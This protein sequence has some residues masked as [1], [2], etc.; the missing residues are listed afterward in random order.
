VLIS[1]WG[2]SPGELRRRPDSAPL[3][4]LGEQDADGLIDHV[5][6]DNVAAARDMTGHLLERGRGRIAAIGPQPHQINGTAQRRLEGY[7]Q[8][9][10]AAGKPAD[11][12]LEVPVRRLHRAEGADA[13]RRLLTVG[14]RPDALF[15]FSDQLALGAMHVAR[16][17]GIRVPDD[18]A[19]AGFDDVEDARYANPSL[20]TVAPDKVQIARAAMECVAHR[21]VERG[22][23]APAR[24]IIAGHHLEIRDSTGLRPSD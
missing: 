14:A 7:R 5:V 2:L 9:L 21:L 3:V 8:A 16:Q 15:C 20:T 6:I 23:R 10:A 12:A 18:L 24:R 4:L 13:M 1:P 19:I 22:D 17:A 11:P